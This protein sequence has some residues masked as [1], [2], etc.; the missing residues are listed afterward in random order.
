VTGASTVVTVDLSSLSGAAAQAGV[1]HAEHFLSRLDRL[2]RSEVDLALELYRDPELLRAVLNAAALP[3]QVERV[4]ISIDHT[5][6]GPFLMVTRGSHFVTC[7]GRG[8]RVGN[9]PVV[10]RADVDAISWKVAR[11]REKLALAQQLGGERGHAREPAVG[12]A[13]A[14]VQDAGVAGLALRRLELAAV[15]PHRGV[16]GVVAPLDAGALHALRLV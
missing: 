1:Q 15:A 8:M 2:P 6:E 7:L 9:L 3:E 14:P 12:L 11:L 13:L 5:V 16:H 10:T 4:A